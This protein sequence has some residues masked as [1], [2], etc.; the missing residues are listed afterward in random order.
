MDKRRPRKQ[1]PVYGEGEHWGVDPLDVRRHARRLREAKQVGPLGKLARFAAVA[2]LVAGAIGVFLNLDTLRQVRF[3]SSR[4]TDL[5]R[6][7]TPRGARATPGAEPGTEVVEDTTIA[8][9]SMPTSLDGEAPA[10]EPQAA[11]APAPQPAAQSPQPAPAAP[12][13]EPSPTELTAD[14]ADAPP[15]APVVPPPPPEPELPPTPE[16][17]GFGLEVMTV[18]ESDATA[19]VVVLRDGGRRGVS[20]FTWWTVDGT[21]TAGSDFARLEPRV[22]RFSVGEQNKTIYIPIV[23]DRAVEGPESF[24]VRVVPGESRDTDAPIAEIEVVILDDD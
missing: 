1:E 14:R 11:E 21:A 16:T 8:G 5:F 22:E 24:Y 10:A 4:I 7:D 6:G 2:L 18:S 19:A 17:L 15:A 20:P 23:G 12:A 13:E 9:V 3:D